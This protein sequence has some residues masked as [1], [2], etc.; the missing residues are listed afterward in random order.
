MLP[1]PGATIG[2]GRQRTS[3]RVWQCAPDNLFERRTVSVVLSRPGLLRR[4][5]PPP[6][7]IAEQPHQPRPYQPQGGGF[8]HR[9]HRCQTPEEILVHAALKRGQ[10]MDDFPK[11]FIRVH[12]HIRPKGL[13][14]VIHVGREH[15][16]CAGR[17]QRWYP[18]IPGKALGTEPEQ[19]IATRRGRQARCWGEVHQLRPRR[20]AHEQVI[21]GRGPLIRAV[22]LQ[23]GGEAEEVPQLVHGEGH[24]IILRAGGL[25]RRAQEEGRLI[26]EDYLAVEARQYVPAGDM[27]RQRAAA[28]AKACNRWGPRMGSLKPTPGPSSTWNA[29]CTGSAWVLGA[30]SPTTTASTTTLATTNFDQVAYR[31]RT[32]ITRLLS[33]RA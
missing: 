5:R 27:L 20:V 30:P 23:E 15:K 29:I 7:A 12:Q 31:C 32:V 26:A 3:R 9:L 25:T 28:K 19:A 4:A 2:R 17:E 8:R 24:E 21:Q 22:G 10:V 6:P 13:R 11:G 1:G 33:Y 14:E 18:V 16:R